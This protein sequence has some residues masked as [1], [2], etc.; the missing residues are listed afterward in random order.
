MELRLLEIIHEAER[1]IDEARV[2]EDNVYKGLRAVYED[3]SDIDY[4]LGNRD[5]KSGVC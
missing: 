2:T 4:I 1:I 3:M 5:F